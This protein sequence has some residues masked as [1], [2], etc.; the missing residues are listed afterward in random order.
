[1]LRK[2][3]VLF[4]MVLIT[5]MFFSCDDDIPW[6]DPSASLEFSTDTILFD[7]IFTNI[8][9]VTRHFKVYNPHKNSVK[10]SYI[11][12]A[13]G[14]NSNYRINVDGVP[15]REFRE[16]ILRGG[17]SIYVFVETTIDPLDSDSPLL[18]EDSIVFNTNGNLQNVKLISWGQDVNVIRGEVFQTQT[19][20]A[21]KPYLVYDHLTVEAGHVLTLDAGVRLHFNKGARLRVAGTLVAE[22]TQEHPVVF[23]GYRTDRAYRNIPGQ[24][25]GIWLMPGS[26][27]NRFVNSRIINAVNGI[28]ADSLGTDESGLLYL[29]NSRIENMTYAGLAGLASGIYAYNTI[30]SGCGHYA[31]IL[32]QGGD[33]RFYHC[34]IGNYWNFST[35]TTPSVFIDND[36]PDDNNGSGHLNVVFANTII[37]GPR[38][39]EIALT[40][41]D[42]GTDN[43]TFSHCLLNVGN[44]V[45]T[46]YP[47]LFENCLNR[48]VP[49]FVDPQKSIF[50][51]KEDSPAIDSGKPEIGLLHPADFEGNSRISDD[52]PDIGAYEWIEDEDEGGDEDKDP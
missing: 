26:S 34:T 44:E 37:H 27:N 10:I 43:I 18:V 21:G 19:L 24:W 39:S 36:P 40:R 47:G 49:G 14:E 41:Y 4:L 33:Y 28:I 12:L 11:I 48:K 23:E 17:D 42:E 22:G 50:M 51:L 31:I 7:T 2:V 25:S 15:G 1:M 46:G 35:R 52:A 38:S 32:G 6:E 8:G 3:F 16:K 5:G 13:G 45:Y 30:I 20:V 29:A 9:S